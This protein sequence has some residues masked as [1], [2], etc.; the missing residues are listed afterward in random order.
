MNRH[1]VIGLDLDNTLV[2]YDSLF[3]ALAMERAL[4]EKTTP[5]QKRAIRDLIR[6]LD[7]GEQQWQVL[8]ALAY[9]RRMNDAILNEGAADFLRECG[10]RRLQVHIVSHRTLSATAD[11]SGTDLRAAA[12]VWMEQQGFFSSSA[13][14][15]DAS[16]VWFES[17]RA[18]K[19][20]R[21]RQLGC[22]HFVD[23]LE[24]VF[25]EP[26]FPRGVVKILYA[27]D[28]DRDDRQVAP[29]VCVAP[30]WAA[31]RGSVFGS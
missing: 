21:I 1:P 19:V 3:H 2:G 26:D 10:T 23:D 9:G 24:E 29:D 18:E 16:R 11:P 7:E 14:G 4:I 27:P 17:T 20:A 13:L 6:R 30:D 28:R 15:L 22:T 5:K 25:L 12:I 8:Q 31:V